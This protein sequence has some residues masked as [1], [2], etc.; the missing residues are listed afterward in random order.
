MSTQ[1]YIT[2]VPPFS[3]NNPA[4]TA[5]ATQKFVFLKAATKVSVGGA[6]APPYCACGTVSLA[7][8]QELASRVLG[9]GPKTPSP[10]S[11]QD[12]VSGWVL[13]PRLTPDWCEASEGVVTDA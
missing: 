5:A 7:N 8:T 13:D 11:H 9:G 12:G 2:I 3:S 1:D 10:A 4:N 6:P